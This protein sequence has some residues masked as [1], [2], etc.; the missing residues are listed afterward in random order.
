MRFANDNQRR[1]VFAKINKG[2]YKKM[3]D[4]MD[5][6][7][8]E[9]LN[10][11]TYDNRR[12]HATQIMNVL[13]GQVDNLDN[14]TLMNLMMDYSMKH[15][16]SNLKHVDWR[17]V[18]RDYAALGHESTRRNLLIGAYD[19][20]SKGLFEDESG[21]ESGSSFSRLDPI[22]SNVEKDYGNF[23]FEFPFNIKEDY[24][25]SKFVFVGEASTLLDVLEMDG[26][27]E[28][29]Q[30][31]GLSNRIVD[32]K[33]RMAQDK[34]FSGKVPITGQELD[35]LKALDVV[36]SRKDPYGELDRYL[37]SKG[38]TWEE[39]S[40]GKPLPDTVFDPDVPSAREEYEESLRRSRPG[41]VV[42]MT[43]EGEKR[44][45]IVDKDGELVESK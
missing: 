3:T 12:F 2:E 13:G 20:P 14:I 26:M 40:A 33:E 7:F 27:S 37:K 22:R 4:F 16:A 28:M 18:D 9:K 17:E 32:A 15:G 10:Y 39:Y 42:Y 35:L 30:L 19:M 21:S 31:I 6:T 41:S 45:F 11:D 24:D 23:R 25:G 34:D 44:K 38:V 36:Y 8:D 29:P 1:A 5:L 43:H